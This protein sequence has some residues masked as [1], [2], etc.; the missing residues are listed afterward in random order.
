MARQFSYSSK[1]KPAGGAHDIPKVLLLELGRSDVVAASSTAV[2]RAAR[3]AVAMARVVCRFAL[4]DDPV[5]L[6]VVT[7]DHQGEEEGQEEEEA[8]PVQ[9]ISYLMG[10][11]CLSGCG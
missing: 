6:V 7:V 3:A 8:V 4:D 11:E 9:T 5:V 10:T 1:S 2:V